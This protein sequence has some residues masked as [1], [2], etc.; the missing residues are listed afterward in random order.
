MEKTG[1]NLVSGKNLVGAF[2]QPKGVFTDLKVLSTLPD[3]EFSAGMAEVIKYGMIGNRILYDRILKLRTPLS[4]NSPE[5]LE[6]I[7]MCCSEKASV[8]QADEKE[9][10]DGLG[11]RALLNLGHTFAHAIEAIAGYGQYLHGEAVSIGLVCALR[12]SKSIGLCSDDPD[13]ELINLLKSYHLPV[14][15]SKT[16]PLPDL[17]EKMKS[18]KKVHRGKLRFVVM[19]EIGSAF[20]KE[21]EDLQEVEKFGEAWEPNDDIFMSIEREVVEAYFESNGFLVR[22][23]GD[24]ISSGGKKTFGTSDPCYL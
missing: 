12:L 10:A 6:L 4:A 13:S 15:L 7:L 19:N 8:V 5:L 22:Q 23:A 17:M 14:E 16:L 21:L 2:H 9:N 20:V 18:D 11:G 3:R 1:I 24:S